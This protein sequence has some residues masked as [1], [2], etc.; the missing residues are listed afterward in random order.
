MGVSVLPQNCCH[1]LPNIVQDTYYLR[2]QQSNVQFHKH[3]NRN[4]TW[5]SALSTHLPQPQPIQTWLV[6]FLEIRVA[7]CPQTSPQLH[8]HISRLPVK[9]HI[10]WLH[11]RN[12]SV[13]GL[14]VCDLFTSR[15]VGRDS[16]SIR[17]G[18]SED[19]M[20]VGTKFSASAQTRPV[21]HPASCIMGTVSIPREKNGRGVALTTYPI[22]RRT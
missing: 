14:F 10:L 4:R 1:W 8:P 2:Y 20:P 17:T 12:R 3:Q 11:Y 18:R 15:S 22:Y 5:S 13:T 9:M 6:L 19:R 21:A 7:A 16:D